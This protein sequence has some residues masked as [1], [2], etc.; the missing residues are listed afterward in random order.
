MNIYI[1]YPPLNLSVAFCAKCARL[2]KRLA[3][4]DTPLVHI[5]ARFDIVKSICNT[6]ERIEKVVVVEILRVLAHTSIIGHNLQTGVHALDGSG[7][8]LR[9]E[10]LYVFG[11]EKKLAIKI[12]FL[13]RVHV[14]DNQLPVGTAC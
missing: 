9:L 1:Y 13:D 11:T 14:R 3:K 10:L 4:E 12:A 8:S 5:A 7:C 2:K 6:V